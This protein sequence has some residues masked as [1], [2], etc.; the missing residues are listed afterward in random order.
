MCP[1][2]SRSSRG[3]HTVIY[4]QPP[5][6]RIMGTCM[7]NMYREASGYKPRIFPCGF[8]I[9]MHCIITAPLWLSWISFLRWKNFS[10]YLN[11][12]FIDF[13]VLVFFNVLSLFIYSRREYWR[14]IQCSQKG[15]DA[16]IHLQLSS[17]CIMGTHVPCVLREA[18]RCEPEFS[19]E[20]ASQSV[21]FNCC[22]TV[23]PLTVF[24]LPHAVTK[25]LNSRR[26]RTVS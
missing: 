26:L 15:V 5:L 12:K 19:R 11:K 6:A 8:S 1:A 3:P 22:T 10:I 20:T 16:M 24:T 14:E 17:C 4:P 13:F 23:Q 21:M 9:K 18:S 7:P 25:R 2:C